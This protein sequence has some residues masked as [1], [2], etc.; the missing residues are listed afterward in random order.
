MNGLISFV[1][2]NECF[3][4]S[5]NNIGA[6]TL[7][8]WL[9]DDIQ[10]SIESLENWK[11]IFSSVEARQMAPGYLGT[12]NSH[13]AMA[14]SEYVYIECEYV[15]EQKVLLTHKQIAAVLNC[16]LDFL[17]K[18]CTLASLVPAPFEVEFI[19]EGVDALNLYIN[20]GG[21][22]GGPSG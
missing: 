1:R 19:A 21:S 3:V 14:T 9:G 16:Y 17:N 7:A 11:T 12:G 5:G 15:D 13:S 18:N 4:P 10:Y 22:L 20:A 8:R 2:P 6:K